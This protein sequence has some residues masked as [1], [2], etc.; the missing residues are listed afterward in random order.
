MCEI[1]FFSVLLLYYM[2]L[3]VAKATA[4]P[5]LQAGLITVDAAA[6]CTP[7]LNASET[8]LHSFNIKNRNPGR[9]RLG[10]TY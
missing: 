1:F 2:L 7:S 9:D 6:Q 5:I 4:H 3:A 8:L 10:F